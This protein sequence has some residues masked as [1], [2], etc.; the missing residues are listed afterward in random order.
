MGSPSE[1][2]IICKKQFAW[3]HL[4]PHGSGR[5]VEIELIHSP[6]VQEAPS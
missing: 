1:S 3:A 4:Q 5:A 2:R 6:E